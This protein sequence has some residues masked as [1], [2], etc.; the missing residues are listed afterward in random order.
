MKP[1][2]GLMLLTRLFISGHEDVDSLWAIDGAGRDV[3]NYT[4]SIKN[5][6]S[7]L[8]SD[9]RYDEIDTREERK[10]TDRAAL[11]LEIFNKFIE[12]CHKYYSCS[13]YLTVD[14]M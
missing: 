5:Q 8:L 11:I 9:L 6:E 3:F 2:L 7:F 12:N 10:V 13:L 14:E 4:I 1:V